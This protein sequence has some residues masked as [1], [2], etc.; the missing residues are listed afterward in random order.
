MN[1]KSAQD[2][3]AYVRELAEEGRMQPLQGG[4]YLVM[5]GTISSLGLAFTALL[6]GGLLALPSVSIMLVW[7][8]LMGVGV[9]FSRKWGREAS[10]TT[11]SESIGNKVERTVW[12]VGGGFLVLVSTMLFLLPWVFPDRFAGTEIEY[13]LLFG[14]MAPLAFGVYAI[15]LAGTA[16]AA[17]AP[18]LNRYVALA[19]V[20]AAITLGLVW[21]IK[22]FVA[23][24]IGILVV[25]V[26]PGFIM[27]DK[28][29]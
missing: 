26:V 23:A 17:R 20:F 15:A 14:M 12:C 19:F 24:I 6:V 1:E 5:W 22:Q 10:G 29:K 2:D 3:L 16:I 18:W 21:D 9:F 25:I 27:M 4:R 11:A 13:Y 8:A 7:F 28:N